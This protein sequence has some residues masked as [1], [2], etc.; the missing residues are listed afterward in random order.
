MVFDNIT[1]THY[2]EEIDMVY[3]L[4]NETGMRKKEK[5]LHQRKEDISR[6]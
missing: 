3:L 5:S 4:Q 2:C 1:C 6:N